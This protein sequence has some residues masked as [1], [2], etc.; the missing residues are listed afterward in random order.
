M[1]RCSSFHR[2]AIAAT[3]IVVTALPRV[4]SAQV[5]PRS[6][7]SDTRIERASA[8][9]DAA[10][11]LGISITLSANARDTLGAL[12]ASL[13]P[14]SPAEQAG[15]DQGNRIADING[16][17][18]RVDAADV[19]Q[20]D[21]EDMVQRR[22]SRAVRTLMPGADVT[23][24]V[25]GGGRYRTVHL[26]LP[27]ALR[28]EPTSVA[29]AAR[30]TQPA[31]TLSG[32]IDGIGQLRSQLRQLA[33]T[34]AD[35]VSA[36]TLDD[37][38]QELAILQRRLRDALG[39]QQRAATSSSVQEA[40]GNDALVGSGLHLAPVGEALADYFGD[41]SVGGLLVVEAEPS[42]AP[43]RKGDVILRVNGTRPDA[44]RLRA[45]F[46]TRRVVRLEV[47]RRQRTMTVTVQAP[48]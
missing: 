34:E 38:D 33:R 2:N 10:S 19:R 22:L 42:W 29:L 18:L 5:R 6:D 40:G 43:L 8:G 11:V 45:A 13:A 47:L 25:F 36:D 16:I 15:I 4:I 46:A 28:A 7:A 23:M 31:V 17:S 44:S 37:A 3:L 30:D 1:I 27:G 48:D 12:V 32:V 9:A 41:E 26:T 20:P 35:G 24:R 14:G 39:K 21:A